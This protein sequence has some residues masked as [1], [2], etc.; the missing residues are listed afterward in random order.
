MKKIFITL[1][2]GALLS[3]CFSIKKNNNP[4]KMNT[5]KKVYELQINRL[6]DIP[7]DILKNINI[8]G[9]DNSP[10]LNEK[11]GEYFNFIFK[12]DTVCFNL[13]GKKAWFSGSKE[14]YFRDTRSPDRNLMV[15]GGSSLYIFD[16]K[17]KEENGGYDV[18]IVYWSKFLL[19]EDDIIKKMK[20]KLK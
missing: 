2:I 8:M 10:I 9:T 14:D 5:D 1:L 15:V 16:D 13:V 6:S 19:S 3:S 18:A 12:L 20:Q 17:Q 4:V 11:E 7:K